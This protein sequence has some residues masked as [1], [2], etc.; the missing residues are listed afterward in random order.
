MADTDEGTEDTLEQ[1][2]AKEAAVALMPTLPEIEDEPPAEAPFVVTKEYRRFAEFADAVR[3]HGRS[4]T[5]AS[6]AGG[7]SG[8]DARLGTVG[9]RARRYRFGD[10]P[11]LVAPLRRHAEHLLHRL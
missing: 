6:G 1:W 4:A 10:H 8:A 11:H 5:H 7:P 2:A 3:R 9:T